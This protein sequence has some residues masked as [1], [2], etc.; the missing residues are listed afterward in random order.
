MMEF[1]TKSSTEFRTGS[2]KVLISIKQ[3][4]LNSVEL[5]KWGG[6]LRVVEDWVY[7]GTEFS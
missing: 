4:E 2:T 1:P 7:E 6:V 3:R 5:G